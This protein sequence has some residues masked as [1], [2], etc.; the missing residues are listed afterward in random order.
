MLCVSSRQ[1]QTQT[2]S[3]L[4]KYFTWIPEVRTTVYSGDDCFIEYEPL[5]PGYIFVGLAGSDTPGDLEKAAKAYN[6]SFT[7]LRSVGGK[8]TAMDEAELNTM[9]Q[10]HS[11][12]AMASDRPGF[13]SGDKVRIKSGP[14]SGSSGVVKSAHKGSVK[15]IAQAFSKTIEMDIIRDE[16]VYLEHYDQN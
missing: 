14:L 12:Y 3:F 13:K 11:E 2:F 6:L 15:V 9:L 7:L 5:Y 1:Y 8:Y 16:F 4:D 10:S